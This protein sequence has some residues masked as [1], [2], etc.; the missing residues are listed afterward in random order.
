MILATRQPPRL[1][2]L[3][4]VLPQY[5][6]PLQRVLSGLRGAGLGAVS[7]GGVALVA[8]ASALVG[9]FAGRSVVRTGKRLYRKI[10][11]R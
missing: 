8:I 5:Y 2:G 11:R 7:T 4:L 1:A 6:T 9:H 10:R 3:G